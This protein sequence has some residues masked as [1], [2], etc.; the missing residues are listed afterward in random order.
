MAQ[1]MVMKVNSFEYIGPNATSERR[2][3]MDRIGDLVVVHE[4][5][6]AFGRK[7]LIPIE[8]WVSQEPGDEWK[9]PPR[10]DQSV[11]ILDV[12]GPAALYEKLLDSVRH[13]GEDI[14]V[15]KRGQ[16]IDFSRLPPQIRATLET[17]LRVPLTRGLLRSTITNRPLHRPDHDKLRTHGV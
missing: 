12:P 14:I 16:F 2:D 6:H 10:A 5:G 8:D 9:R 4:D 11:M 7:T 17:D 13:T 3:Q 1:L 15:A